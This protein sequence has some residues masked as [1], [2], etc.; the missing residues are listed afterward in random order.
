MKG[1][2]A[3]T[4]MEQAMMLLI[5][6]LAATLCLQAFV[7]ADTHSRQNSNRDRAMVQ[8]QSAAEVL[9]ARQ[10]NILAAAES[11]G[12]QAD[13]GVWTLFWDEN[14]VQTQKPDAFQLCATP[15]DQTTDLLGS[16]LLEIRD[17]SGT[18]LGSLRIAW[19]EVL[20]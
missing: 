15:Q 13:N 7:W 12:G 17:Q 1:K 18:I 3:L 4:L 10:G 20:P 9:K 6:A 19:Q 8:L 11:M 5:L 2:T 16:A 14:W